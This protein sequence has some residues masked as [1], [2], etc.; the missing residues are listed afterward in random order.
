MKRLVILY[1]TF[2]IVSC[3]YTFY[4]GS[5]NQQTQ[6]QVVLSGSNFK[7]LGS[8]SGSATYKKQKVSIRT[9]EGLFTLA[10]EDMLEKAKAAGITLTGS[11]TLINIVTDY[12]ENPRRIT[13][14]YSADII[15]F[16]K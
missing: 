6:T 15:E 8:F 2:A 3:K 4:G 10:K 9:K 16:I 7:V 13:V 11:R 14:T 12:I 1:F 5:V